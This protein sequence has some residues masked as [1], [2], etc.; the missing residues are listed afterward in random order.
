MIENL[1]TLAISAIVAA[2]AILSFALLQDSFLGPEIEITGLQEMPIITGIEGEVVNPGVYTLP[3]NAR[4]ADLVDAAGGLTRNADV[5][6]LNLAARIGDGETIRIPSLATASPEV[7]GNELININTASAAELDE[8]PGIGEVL[9]ARI[10]EHRE[11]FGPFAS[12]DQLI[13]IE[14]INQSTIDELRPL[15]TVGG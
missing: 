1:R 4:L 15:V 11:L 10:I 3:S 8:L 14:G 12:I 6:S 2:V 9:A 7:S 13:E 5:T